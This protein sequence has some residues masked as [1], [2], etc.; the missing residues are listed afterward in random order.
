MD[1]EIR[2]Q[3]DEAIGEAD[4]LLFVVDARAGLHPAR[5]QRRRDAAELAEAVAARGEQGGRSAR[6]GFLRVLP[7]RRRGGFPGLGQNGKNS[8]DLLDAVVG[9]LPQVAAGAGELAA[10]RGDRPAERREVVVREPLARRGAPRRRRRR[11]NDARR[12]RHADALS[13]PPD[14][15]RRHGRSAAP[16]EDRRRH[17]VLFVAAHAARD[18]ARRISASSWST[19]P[20]ARCRTRTSRSPRSRGKAGEG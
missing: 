3:V 6:Y 17:G 9:R 2:R 19:R 15:V 12:D 20:R 13:R 11:G 5:L 4:L 16:V 7:A 8:G 18:R 14:R 10:R 1:V